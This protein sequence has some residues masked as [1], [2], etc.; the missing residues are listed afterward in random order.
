MMSWM[1]ST[2]LEALTDD[3]VSKKMRLDGSIW[4]S[5]NLPLSCSPGPKGCALSK[6]HYRPCY[7]SSFSELRYQPLE[8]L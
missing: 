7:V 5:T 6:Q 8:D 1:L 4:N 3:I 2:L